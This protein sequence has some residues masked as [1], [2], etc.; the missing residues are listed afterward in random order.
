MEVSGQIKL[1]ADLLW[2]K[3]TL[4]TIGYEVGWASETIYMLWRSNYSDSANLASSDIYIYPQYIY[5]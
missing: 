2:G 1:P 3:Q 5:V 4:V